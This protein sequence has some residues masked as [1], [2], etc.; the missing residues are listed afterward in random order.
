MAAAYQKLVFKTLVHA[1][2]LINAKG[3]EPYK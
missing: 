2:R 3:L 1:I